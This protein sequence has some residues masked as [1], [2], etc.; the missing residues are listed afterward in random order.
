VKE[1]IQRHHGHITAENGAKGLMFTI[2]LPLMDLIN[3][4]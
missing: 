1:I 3:H 4:T 2:S